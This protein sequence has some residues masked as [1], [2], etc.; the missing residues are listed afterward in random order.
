[1]NELK[2]KPIL[3]NLPPSEIANL[4]KSLGLRAY[5][6]KQVLEW[7][8]RHLATSFV[9]M[10]SISKE[11]QI[12]LDE[13]TSLGGLEVLERRHASD[14]TEKFLFELSDGERIE[15]VFIRGEK[16]NTLCISTQV[17]CAMGCRF[18]LTGKQGLRRNLEPY[19]MVDQFLSIQRIVGQ[20][21]EIRNIVLMGMGE[22][23]DNFDRVLMALSIFLSQEALCL[24]S[25]RITLSTC[26]LIPE[27]EKLGRSGLRVQLAVSL[28]A[29]T[30]RVRDRIMPINRKY[31]ISELLQA[32][33]AYPLANRRRIT[34]EYVLLGGVNDK[35]DDALKLAALLGGIQCKVNLIPF[36]PFDGVGFNPPKEEALLRFQEILLAHRFTAT[37]RKSRGGEILA[38]CGQLTSHAN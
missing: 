21:E 27:I 16:R 6:K 9:E 15:A 7:I 10:S 19:E 1:M 33:R 11:D 30:D 35:P 38:A 24:S 4:F 26:G 22:P 20:D 36:N 23:L 13:R 37:I 2:S 29:T 25:R 8:Y 17:G 32:L 28:N 14:G 5:R 34:F 12:L 31:P 18:C 3:K